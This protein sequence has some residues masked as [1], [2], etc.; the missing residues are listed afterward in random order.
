MPD[1]QDWD[2]EPESQAEVPG[3]GSS[4]AEPEEQLQIMKPCRV[5]PAV[6][7]SANSN[8]DIDCYKT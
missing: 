7:S 5:M 1:K 8:R 3:L 2:R 4:H 6:P